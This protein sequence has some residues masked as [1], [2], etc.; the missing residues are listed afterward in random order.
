MQF[1]LALHVGLGGADGN[2]Y[3]WGSGCG[4]F[5]DV[6]GSGGADVG[7]GDARDVLVDGGRGTSGCG[8]SCEC[9]R[10][11]G[12]G[13]GESFEWADE[14]EDEVSE[15]KSKAKA[16]NAEAQSPEVSGAEKDEAEKSRAE[17]RR[18]R[19]RQFG[20]VLKDASERGV[21]R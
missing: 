14:F 19:R 16:L 4:D 10:E 17:K 6:G 18:E 7:V 12:D 21:R 15:E 2:F 3:G 8:A 5:P 9:G 1:C 13:A 20:F 11:I